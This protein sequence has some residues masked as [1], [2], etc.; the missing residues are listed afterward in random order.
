MRKG[1]F[2]VGAI[3][4][5]A[6]F[7][8]CSEGKDKLGE[9]PGEATKAATS[10][11]KEFQFVSE[12]FEPGNMTK[13][14]LAMMKTDK[15]FYRYN[16]G[17][18]ALYYYDTA[19]EK[20]MVLCN[21]PECRHDGN[22]FCVGTNDKYLY[23]DQCLYGDRMLRYALEMTETQCYFKVLSV[24]L[25]GSV[26][27]EIATVL[28][29]ARPTEGF[30]AFHCSMYA[31][32]NKVI[33]TMNGSEDYYGVASLDLNTKEVIYWYEEPFGKENE[34]IFDVTG[35]GDYFYYCKKEGKKTV[36]YRRHI[37][38]GATE[39]FRLLPNFAGEYVVLDEDRIAYL[40][41]TGKV[42]CLHRISTGENVE[43]TKLMRHYYGYLGDGLY[44][45]GPEKKDGQAYRLET[46]GTYV[47]AVEAPL[48]Y[49]KAQAERARTEAYIYVLNH[50]L[51]EVALVDME[52]TVLELDFEAIEWASQCYTLT[53]RYMGEDIYW[54]L[55]PA[56]ASKTE[57]YVFR[58]KRSDFVAGEP[59][60]TFVYQ[61]NEN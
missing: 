1:L 22:E 55:V 25:D 16:S 34:V 28:E 38:T 23:L 45:N 36:L 24:A 21:K 48:H 7:A 10:G 26:M 15:G 30:S 13:Y 31:H 32:R 4:C 3:L 41:S 59:K 54:E 8:G 61:Y 12:D 57:T 56:D 42:V 44:G 49:G 40:K 50:E 33:L 9:Q 18:G 53:L 60:F 11:K 5:L 17:D 43:Q 19:T 46:D 2:A 37:E 58:C 51:E 52:K 35:A 39:S 14:M 6:V 20:S 27:D 29:F 47:Y